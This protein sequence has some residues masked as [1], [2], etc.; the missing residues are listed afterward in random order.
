MKNSEQVMTRAIEELAEI[1]AGAFQDMGG[2]IPATLV[3]AIPKGLLVLPL[4]AMKWPEAK[5]AIANAPFTM[6]VLE[7]FIYETRNGPL[8]AG[9]IEDN[10]DARLCLIY[11]A[12]ARD[13][14]RAC[15]VQFILKP[16]RG[17]PS[18]APLKIMDAATVGIAGPDHANATRH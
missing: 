13:G 11:L 16:E 14:A 5:D 12:Q 8:Q 7:G 17:K 1:N 2:E 9:S 4:E 6:T 3:V 18:L 10:P 15:A